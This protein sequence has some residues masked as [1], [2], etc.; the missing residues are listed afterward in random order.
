MSGYG[1]K[2]RGYDERDSIQTR[3]WPR[4]AKSAIRRL[5]AECRKRARRL[6]RIQIAEQAAA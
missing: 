3:C 5:R 1:G 2:F 6:G 4:H